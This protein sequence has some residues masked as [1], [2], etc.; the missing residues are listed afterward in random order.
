MCLAP[1]GNCA[2]DPVLETGPLKRHILTFY[3][4]YPHSVFIYIYI[5]VRY[6]PQPMV[7]LL[8]LICTM[9]P[10]SQNKLLN[11]ESQYVGATRDT[12]AKRQML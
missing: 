1:A 11:F 12:H 3:S 4:V 5:F 6:L 10:L 2:R 9:F 8:S 7:S